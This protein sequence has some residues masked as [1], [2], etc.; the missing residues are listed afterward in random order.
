MAVFF[1]IQLADR[2]YSVAFAENYYLLHGGEQLRVEACPAWCAAC[3]RF[4]E[5]EHIRGLDVMAA[6]V[7]ELE[8]L[9]ARPG[10]IPE[11]RP[12]LLRRWP[13]QRRR[14]EWRRLRASR[15]RCLTC[16]SVEVTP[17]DA[18]VEVDVPGVGR[19]RG[20]FLLLSGPQVP[21]HNFSP[22]GLRIAAPGQTRS[23]E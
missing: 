1:Q 14:L 19:C 18:N 3:G 4:V 2:V 5:A 17:I 6:D 23:T 7:R 20:G 21:V 22:E 13:E 10:L 9:A 16:G 15:A 11:D 8:N 12:A